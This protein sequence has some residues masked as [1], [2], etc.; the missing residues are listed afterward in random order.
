MAGRRRFRF[1]RG[2][3]LVFEVG[4]VPAAPLEL[5]ARGGELLLVSVLMTFRAV[6]QH[7][8]I[9]LLQMIIFKAARFAAISI[10]RHGVLSVSNKVDDYTRTEAVFS[11]FAK[12]LMGA[13]PVISMSYFGSQH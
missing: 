10:D 11:C 4:G 9:Q 7:R 1:W 12:P 2:R 8:V 5:K 3:L 13:N 6:D